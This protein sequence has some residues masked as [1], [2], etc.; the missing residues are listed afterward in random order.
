MRTLTLAALWIGGALALTACKKSVDPAYLKGFE[1]IAAETCACV[2]K[3]TPGECGMKALNKE[4]KPPGGEPP[5]IYEESLSEADQAKIKAAKAKAQRAAA[6]SHRA[7]A[8]DLAHAP[9]F[10]VG[11]R[12]RAARAH[13]TSCGSA[14]SPR[15]GRARG[16]AR[17][18]PCCRST[19]SRT[20]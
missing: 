20:I 8:P 7:E 4:P 5:G 3:P 1:D 17:A 15:S 10:R 16:R 12:S 2:D 9:L 11:A 18:S 13:P 19:S 6:R 14:P